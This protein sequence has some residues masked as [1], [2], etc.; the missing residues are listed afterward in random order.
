MAKENINS[1]KWVTDFELT[2]GLDFGKEEV[3]QLNENKQNTFKKHKSTR[4]T[5]RFA[6]LPNK[7]MHTILEKKPLDENKKTNELACDNI[8]TK[9]EAMQYLR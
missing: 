6:S 5:K 9:V 4:Q 1:W 3:L 7:E 8:S 2:F